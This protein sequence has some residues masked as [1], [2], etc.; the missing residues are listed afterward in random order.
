[1]TAIPFFA[2]LTAAASNSLNGIVCFGLSISN[3]NFQPAIV[4]GTVK[5]ANGP[6]VG[7]ETLNPFL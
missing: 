1:M 7:N 5:A 3:A 4:P 6:L 2:F